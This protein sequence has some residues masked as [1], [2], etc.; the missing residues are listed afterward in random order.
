ME[1]SRQ[2]LIAIIVI[3]AIAA[4][5]IIGVV[6]YLLLPPVNNY[7]Y[8]GFGEEQKP[9]AQTIKVGIL[10]DMSWSGEG[11]YQGAW[12]AARDINLAGGI[13]IGGVP[14]YIGLVVED[15]KEQLGTQDE[16][17]AAAYRMINHAP[18]FC[19]GGFRT[20][21]FSSYQDIMMTAKIPFIITGT[22]S[23]K[24]CKERVG[25]AYDFYKYTFR[26]MPTNNKIQGE[27]MG[28]YIANRIIEN[29]TTHIGYGVDNITLVYEQLDWTQLVTLYVQQEILAVHP[30]ISFNLVPIPAGSTKDTYSFGGLYTNVMTAQCPLVIQIVSSTS[31]GGAMGSY[32]GIY[33]PDALLVGINILAQFSFYLTDYATKYNSTTPLGQSTG[34][35]YEITSHAYADLNISDQ[36]LPF[37]AAYRAQWATDPIYTS[38]GG[39]NGL[40]MGVNAITLAG[41]T[42][43]NIVTGLETYD[44]DSPYPGL[45]SSVA[46]DQYHDYMGYNGSA[47]TEGL[48]ETLWRQ[49]QPVNNNATTFAFDFNYS[50]PLVPGW[51]YGDESQPST[52]MDNWAPSPTAMLPERAYKNR[53]LFPH[54]W[55]GNLL[56]T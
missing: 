48:A 34:G 29:I 23:E 24:F 20:E 49:W 27:V 12:I 41:F 26:V 44:I 31:I 47:E 35:M 10:D 52:L 45:V 38:I 54:W 4:G 7:E 9:L 28:K 53:I 21:R 8:P 25:D 22:A 32:Y 42:P 16:A 40:R 17:N 13:V 39:Y 5:A 46:F 15:T 11:C 51:Y 14:Y 33:K 2:R 30:G 19:L 6:I 56:I 1:R 50:N 18:H 43:D 36:L 3:A 55:S 37:L